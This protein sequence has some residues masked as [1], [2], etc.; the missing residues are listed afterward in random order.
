M[1]HSDV[2]G[3]AQGSEMKEDEKLYTWTKFHVRRWL[4]RDFR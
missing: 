3:Q 4:L 1:T 2:I